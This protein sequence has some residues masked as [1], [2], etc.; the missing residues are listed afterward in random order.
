MLPLTIVRL[1]PRAL[2]DLYVD[3]IYERLSLVEKR[4][5][6]TKQLL[7]DIEPGHEYTEGFRAHLERK[8]DDGNIERYALTQ[9]IADVEDMRFEG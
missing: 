2:A 4:V 6:V 9:R 7:D 8:L 3:R 1:L 5:R